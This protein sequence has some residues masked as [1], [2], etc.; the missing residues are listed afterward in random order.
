MLR[1]LFDEEP[2]LERLFLWAV[3]ARTAVAI[4]IYLFGWQDFFGPDAYTYHA[5]GAGLA[6]SWS[7][8]NTLDAWAES[9]LS[10]DTPGWG[11]YYWVAG[12]YSLT[13]PNMLVVQFAN[14]V[15]GSAVPILIFEISGTV[16]GSLEVA[17]KA[18]VLVAFFPSIVL[19]SA[20][21][22]KDPLILVAICLVI[23][24]ALSLRE[25]ITFENIFLI[26]LGLFALFALR[27]YVF[28]ILGVA[29]VAWML[30]TSF[31]G[32]RSLVRQVAAI[33]VVAGALLSLGVGE[34]APDHYSRIS[35]DEIQASRA[36]MGTVAE[37]GFGADIDV[38]AEG[39]LAK[40]A[41]LGLAYVLLAPF[42][43]EMS[44]FRQTVTLPEMIL[45][46]G[47]LP[48]LVSGAWYSLK[49]RMT[50]SSG[51]LIFLTGLLLAY[52]V[53]LNNV[54]TAYRQRAQL[55]PFFLVFVVVGYTL[56]ARRRALQRS[57]AV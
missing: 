24:F 27:F 9:R 2:F 14:A 47:M 52:S 23:C 10:T 46:W 25:R 1:G 33:A 51:I 32:V 18:A 50:E 3:A 31:T 55:L 49:Y 36:Y 20:Q 37:S 40:A 42:P 7:G 54:G 56:R 30:L 17:R 28:Y 41:T 4:V 26:S 8:E 15:I 48:L 5:I 16:Y 11:M 6:Q 45:W 43:W 12:L 53:Y 35:I 21:G 44:S 38:R 34:R 57:T 39:G 19:W 22:L 29:L 13:G